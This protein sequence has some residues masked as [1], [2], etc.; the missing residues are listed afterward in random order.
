MRERVVSIPFAER[1]AHA[2]GILE[3]NQ[4]IG[5]RGMMKLWFNSRK[6]LYLIYERAKSPLKIR[7]IIKRNQL[8]RLRQK[9]AKALLQT[10]DT[11]YAYILP[12]AIKD[13]KE[14]IEQYLH[15]YDEE[16]ATN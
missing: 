16:F 14:V 8:K 4:C 5:K 9:E 1:D 10:M 15:L 7:K 13:G 6:E 11:D 12:L 3:M 2:E